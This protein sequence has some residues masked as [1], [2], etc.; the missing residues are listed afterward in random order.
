MPIRQD[1]PLPENTEEKPEEW[2]R[3]VFVSWY[4]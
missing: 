4:F 1:C 3:L 2:A